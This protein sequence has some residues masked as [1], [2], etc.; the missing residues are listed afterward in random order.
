MAKKSKDIGYLWEYNLVKWL[1]S[2]GWSAKRNGTI[3]GHKDEGDIDGVPWCW[4]A[5]DVSELGPKKLAAIMDAT[6]AQATNAGKRYYGIALKRRGSKTENGYFIMPLWQAERMMH[7]VNA[8]L[9]NANTDRAGNQGSGMREPP[10]T[11]E[12]ETG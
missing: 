8:W 12:V 3:N 9:V 4:Q 2:L 11:G 7:I 6:A 10:G 1:R 5:K